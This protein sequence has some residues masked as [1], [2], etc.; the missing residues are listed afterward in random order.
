MA[1][2]WLLIKLLVPLM[3]LVVLLLLL[4]LLTLLFTSGASLSVSMFTEPRLLLLL[5]HEE[6]VCEPE[7][8]PARAS[9]V[10]G[11]GLLLLGSSVFVR[12]DR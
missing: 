2:F 8:V 12:G 7:S 6:G 1:E 11:R 3:M 9:M 4:I 10:N 5:E